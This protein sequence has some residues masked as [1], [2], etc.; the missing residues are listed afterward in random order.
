MATTS[1]ESKEGVLAPLLEDFHAGRIDRRA[2]IRTAL[3]AGASTAAV[4]GALGEAEAAAQNPDMGNEGVPTDTDPLN[5][6]QLQKITAEMI[7]AIS[8][9]PFVMAMRQLK[10]TPKSERLDLA[11]EILT[12]DALRHQ[13]VPLPENMRI[14]SRYFE[15]GNP[16]TIGTPNI[17]EANDYGAFLTT[18]ANPLDP[19]AA[20]LAPVLSTT[21][22]GRRT[23]CACA[24]GGAGTVCGGAGGGHT[25]LLLVEPL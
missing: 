9:A 16:S 17:I 23:T 24:C 3:A 4:Y 11:A 5:A 2:L 19:V 15:R 1:G 13:G 6:I 21:N 7:A 10:S 14:T 8:S 12:P 25:G 18:G 22:R 20:G